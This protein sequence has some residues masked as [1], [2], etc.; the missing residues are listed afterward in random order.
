M[1]RISSKIIILLVLVFGFTLPAHAQNNPP[2]TNSKWSGTGIA[3]PPT[4]VDP[5]KANYGTFNKDEDLKFFQTNRSRIGIAH[6]YAENITYVLAGMGMLALVIMAFMG[7]FSWKVLTM[8][9]GGLA[10]LAGF[11]YVVYFV[12]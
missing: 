1:T 12:S 9:L 11:Q 3:L 8:I 4:L 2:T 5:T 10:I 7:K 6:D